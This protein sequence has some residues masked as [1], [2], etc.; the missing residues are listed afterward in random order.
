MTYP[1]LVGLAGNLSGWPSEEPDAGGWVDFTIRE[2]GIDAAGEH[3]ARARLIPLEGGYRLLVGHDMTECYRFGRIMTGAMTV[4]LL[5]TVLVGLLGGV[6]MSRRIL[7]RL[8]AVNRTSR[9]ILGGALD[10]R[11][12]V[13]GRGDEFDQL[14][15]NLNAMLERLE[16][17]MTGMRQV[18]DNVAHDLRSP[19]S[20]LR[21]RLEV[22]LLGRADT[23]E[24]YREAL[25]ATVTEID[26]VLATFNAS[27]A[28]PA[29][30]PA[31]C[32]TP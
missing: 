10:R 15:E 21:S 23:Q 27:S 14:G 2:P 9:E 3:A 28:S 16:K 32:R 19:L 6:L 11:I 4:A 17:L 8:E 18:T 29:S 25:R 30:S 12:P 1:R 7:G 20:R 26:G 31:R 24:A 5:I 22:T 13:T